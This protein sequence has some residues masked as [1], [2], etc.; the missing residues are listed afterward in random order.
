[1]IV[2]ELN[3]NRIINVV[4]RVVFILFGWA[5]IILKQFEAI[6]LRITQNSV[7]DIYMLFFVFPFAF[8]ETKLGEANN[9]WQESICWLVWISL[10]ISSSLYE[11]TVT[12]T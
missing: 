11:M 10:V 6:L 7:L 3:L 8:S 9:N 1:M 5:M 12:V 4:K 2:F